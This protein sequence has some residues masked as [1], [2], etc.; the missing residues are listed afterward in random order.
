M[1]RL[2]RGRAKIVALT[3]DADDGAL[4]AIVEALTPDVFQLHGRESPARVAEIGRRFGVATMKAIGVATADDF[5]MAKAYAGTADMLLFDAKPAKDAKLPGGNGQAFDWRLLVDFA[6]ARPRLL[7]GGLD[8]DN[9]AAAIALSGAT[10]VD[11]SSGVESAP[12][13]KENAKIAAFVARAREA[14]ALAQDKQSPR[15]GMRA[16][17][18]A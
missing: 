3:V 6:C 7:S 12:G 2:A 4:G 11:V 15:D 9:V 10:G 17:R 5:A 14:F 8:A 18:V 13:V 1:G 16:G